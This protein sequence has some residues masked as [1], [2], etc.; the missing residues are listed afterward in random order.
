MA[1]NDTMFGGAGNDTF[2]AV[3]GDGNDAYD[4]GSGTDTYDLS[5]TTAA[6]TVNLGLGTS[7][8]TQAGT[9]TLTGIE[10]V[11]GSSA[12]DT[13]TGD[14]QNNVLDGG[15]GADTMAGGLGDD[16]YVVDDGNDS[17]ND[18]GGVDTVDVKTI[19]SYTLGANLENLTFIG[20]GNFT[21]TGNGLDNVIT[22]GVN[23]D[24]LNG[25][26]GNDTLIGGAG[27]DTLT[28]GG[29][30]DVFKYLASG[31][32]TDT[33]TDFTAHGGAVAE[34]DLMDISGLGITAATFAASVT[35]TNAGG[36]FASVNIGA[37]HMRLANTAV[38]SINITDFRLA[39]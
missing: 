18:T 36:G 4:G 20:T 12:N 29:G 15:K 35:V 32:G 39:P 26:L 34:R 28:G 16:T 33:I 27:S 2:I 1:G 9:D 6:A 5:G 13:I 11:V 22:G 21:G 3:S 17:I 38:A 23:S 30:T 7:T 14:G 19:T 24:K 31:F 37:D 8:S 25:G 10:N